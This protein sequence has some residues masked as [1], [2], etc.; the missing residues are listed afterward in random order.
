MGA[1]C[2]SATGGQRRAFRGRTRALVATLTLVTGLAVTSPPARTLSHAQ[3]PSLDTVLSRVAS[4][5]DELQERLVGVV[6]EERYRQRVADGYVDHRHVTLR[7]DYLLVR[8]EGSARPYGFRDVFEV[9]G[10][11]VRDRED[12]LTQLFLSP[13]VTLNRQIEGIL[14]D[15]ARY[16]V[17]GVQRTTNTP[18]LPLLFL[19][20]SHRSRFEFERADDTAPELDMDEPDAA[21]G[22]RVISYRE[23]SSPTIIQRR[24]GRD[25]PAAGRYWVE[26]ATGRVLLTELVLSAAM[27]NSNITTRYADNATMGHSVPVEMRERYINWN[28]RQRVNGTADYTRF[29]RFQVRVDEGTLP[30][31][32]SVDAD[33]PR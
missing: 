28:N 1:S 11:P 12:R 6:M 3:K 23:V 9:N 33:C 8:L 15:S 32:E 17:G 13:T 4:Y 20:S 22:V 21:S 19:T 29:R 30:A 25:T 10:R 16:N 31:T 26:P 27:V 7:S 2:A 14:E 24:G 5:V 18:T